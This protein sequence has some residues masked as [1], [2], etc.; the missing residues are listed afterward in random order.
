MGLAKDGSIGKAFV[1]CL[2]IPSLQNLNSL[3]KQIANIAPPGGP[4]VIFLSLNVEEKNIASII[5]VLDNQIIEPCSNKTTYP[6]VDRCISADGSRGCD[7]KYGFVISSIY[8]K[9]NVLLEFEVECPWCG[10]IRWIPVAKASSPR[11]YRKN[12]KDPE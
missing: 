6:K 2:K 5:N 10:R 4:Y 3:R 9:N 12:R 8:G 11:L 7:A 1:I